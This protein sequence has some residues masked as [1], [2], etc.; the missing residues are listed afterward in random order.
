MNILLSFLALLA[1]TFTLWASIPAVE[2]VS[3]SSVDFSTCEVKQFRI[4]SYY[5]PLPNQSSYA[6]GNYEAEKRMN[7][8]WTHGASGR[9]VFN[10]MIAAPKTY[11]FWTTIFFPALWVWSV[12][13]RGGAIVHAW[14][15]GE[16]YDRIDIWAWKWEEWLAR[17]MWFGVQ[18]M[19]AYVC[20]PWVVPNVVGFDFDAMAYDWPS[21]KQIIRE[22]VMN[23]WR[24]DS[25]VTL[26]QYALNKLGY[27]TWT[28]SKG[29]FGEWTHAAVCDFQQQSFGLSAQSR[30]C[31]QYWPQT[32]ATLRSTL[33]RTWITLPDIRTVAYDEI[34][35]E[36]E[37]ATE[38]TSV[39]QHVVKDSSRSKAHN[40]EL[41]QQWWSLADYVFTTPL[42]FGDQGEEVNLLQRKLA[43]LWYYTWVITSE[44]DQPTHNAVI[45]F[46]KN[47]GVITWDEH[48]SLHW[49]V[50]PATRRAL[51]FK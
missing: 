27:S 40:T 31:G 41:F 25:A 6:M 48:P 29:T 38:P 22:T 20:E 11:A 35:E 43:Y 39:A 30:W 32:S 17:A 45:A 9:A 36:Q 47:E 3:L 12:Q 10:G 16:K 19:E 49:Y 5:S 2:A 51:N 21:M 28:D 42:S 33:M 15:R 50:G 46:Q 18:Y 8:E 13:D 1:A 34:Q 26:L 37:V 24:K 44:F 7:G 4:T 23:K 14:E